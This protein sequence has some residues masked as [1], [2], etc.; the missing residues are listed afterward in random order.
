MHRVSSDKRRRM[1]RSSRPTHPRAHPVA[2]ESEG[3]EAEHD[4]PLE[5]D[6]LRRVVVQAVACPQ[7]PR[8]GQLFTR[9]A[10]HAVVDLEALRG[11]KA[12][13][14]RQT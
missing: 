13:D 2:G 8:V 6:E 12:S 14:V 7:Q 10:T 3:K 1:R 4:P 5:H 11:C 9:Q